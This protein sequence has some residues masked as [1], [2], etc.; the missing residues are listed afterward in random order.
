MPFR[1]HHCLP[2]L[3][4]ACVL[5]ARPA[6]ALDYNEA[7][8]GD[9]SNAGLSPTVLGVLTAGSNQIFGTIASG[10]NGVD[11]DYFTVTVPTGFE[12]VS[13]TPL[14]GTTVGDTAS[15][16]GLE[17]GTQVTVPTNAVTATGLLGWTH[18]TVADI[19][20]N[21]LPTMGTA[22]FGSTGFTPPLG[23]GNYAFWIQDADAARYGFDIKIQ[24]VPEPG[25]L[26][27]L[28]GAGL[29]GGLLAFARWRRRARSL[30]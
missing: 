26:T 29:S 17:A 9:L 2:L 3:G 4:L 22:G 5:L 14:S 20:T 8:S 13:L 1:R 18:Y 21:L 16:L 23:A 30:A 6:Q 24:A 25:S 27:L 7:V 15:F 19:G 10:P 11:R 12:F 28:G